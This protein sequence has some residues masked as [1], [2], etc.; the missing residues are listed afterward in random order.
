MFVLH[1]LVSLFELDR[2]NKLTL[3]LKL[4]IEQRHYIIIYR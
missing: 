3:K 4:F 2:I 1:I